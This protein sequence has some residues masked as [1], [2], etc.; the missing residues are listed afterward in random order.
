MSP[1]A[2]E[3]PEGPPA[4][5]TARDIGEVRKSGR[6]LDALRAGQALLAQSPEDRWMR[7]A[8]GWCF[9]QLTKEA[10]SRGD[11]AQAQA[12]LRDFDQL[13]I[14]RDD[15]LI[16]QKVDQLRSNAT[17]WGAAMAQASAASRA[18][19]LD[20][21]LSHWH[22][23]Q[24]AL[25]EAGEECAPADDVRERF[26][27]GY[28]WD[29]HRAV[30]EA[31]QNRD[32]KR[33]AEL[34]RIY[35][36]LGPARP[37]VLHSRMLSR[38]LQATDYFGDLLP[39]LQWWDPQNLRDPEDFQGEAKDDGTPWPS[40]AD[41]LTKALSQASNQPQGSEFL[42]WI[43]EV[44]RG[45]EPKLA[46]SL[47]PTYWLA[48]VYLRLGQRVEAQPRMLAVVRAKST[49]AWAWMYL[50]R[51]FGPHEDE[52]AL[53][54]H[55]RA[56]QLAGQTPMFSTCRIQLAKALIGAG[57]MAEA[58]CELEQARAVESRDGSGAS[59]PLTQLLAE[60]EG[61]E[62]TKPDNR[63]LYAELADTATELIT[64]NL[65]WWPAVIS[66]V[67]RREGKR[68]L[69]FASVLEPESQ[70]PVEALLPGALLR[71]LGDPRPGTPVEVRLEENC[72]KPRGAAV[73]ARDGVPWDILPEEA[74]AV[75]SVNPAKGILHVIVNRGRDALVHRDAW[76]GPN[77]L[78]AQV[79]GDVVWV[80]LAPPHRGDL[81]TARVARPAPEPPEVPILRT[82][83]GTFSAPRPKGGSPETE[84]TSAPP[85][86]GF[87][88]CN[89][90]DFYVGRA[91]IA[92]HGLVHGSPV[93]GLGLYA[94]KPHSTQWDWKVVRIDRPPA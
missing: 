41:T 47:W 37:S 35:S 2:P 38:V 88:G 91:L 89:G 36:R 34:L 8:V 84:E 24:M 14:P 1:P 25:S 44:L 12:F 10:L 63:R 79:P 33:M 28:G 77:D 58:R 64:G 20:E 52:A 69:Y 71:L 82:L 54:C 39:F 29:L 17:P 23:V 57:R 15:E 31:Q 11:S 56:A 62:A 61:V 55:A 66:R 42:P 81:H 67:S 93:R 30:Y 85:P 21:A 26:R 76:A 90:L 16:H 59:R 6:P 48:K 43:A 13:Q 46:D 92:E 32:G 9:W 65:P 68:P 73:R 87:V 5:Q 22:R 94:P 83:D 4:P 74:A 40:L 72:E 49:E 51:T 7:S 60:T 80:R 70:A 27:T 75:E 86:F 50:A 3:T 45:L 19:R 78:T 18:R 53:A